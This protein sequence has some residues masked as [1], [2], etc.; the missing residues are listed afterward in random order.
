M[1]GANSACL[2]LTIAVLLRLSPAIYK[3]LSCLLSRYVAAHVTVAELAARIQA[4][5]ATRCGANRASLIRI[6]STFWRSGRFHRRCTIPKTISLIW[7]DSGRRA[8][9]EL[10]LEVSLPQYYW[11]RGS[12]ARCPYWPMPKCLKLERAQAKLLASMDA[13]SKAEY[14]AS[15]RAGGGQASLH[16][17]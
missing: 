17:P 3:L 15:L 11:S 1:P 14:D 12:R 2:S 9:E 8:E 13:D 7:E 6:F 16:P 10:R 4:N 5:T